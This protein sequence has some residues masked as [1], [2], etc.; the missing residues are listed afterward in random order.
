RSARSR[1]PSTWSSS[2]RSFGPE[3]YVAGGRPVRSR[4]HSASSARTS[5]SVR[6]SCQTIAWCTGWPVARSHT[7]VVS[8]WL[9]MPTATGV[10]EPSASAT[11]AST[12]V[13]ISSASCSTQPGRGKI[14]RCSR[15]ATDTIWPA[16]SK[17][18]QR[19]EVVPWSIAAMYRS[20]RALSRLPPVGRPARL[21]GRRRAPEKKGRYPHTTPSASVASS[22][23]QLYAGSVPFTSGPYPWALA[24]SQVSNLGSTPRPRGGPLPPGPPPDPPPPDPSPLGP[25]DPPPPDAPPP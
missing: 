18:L 9:V 11:T 10:A 25:A 4:N 20:I 8:R 1:R 5:S 21:A 12:L 3:K 23:Y 24:S 19:L 6:V 2:Q 16:E 7:S 17:T 13:Q 14:W 22:R 15:W